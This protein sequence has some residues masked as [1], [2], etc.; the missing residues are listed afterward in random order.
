M[1]CNAID[2]GENRDGMKPHSS[3]VLVL[4][5]EGALERRS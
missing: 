4:E 2:K 5:D 1:L 3:L